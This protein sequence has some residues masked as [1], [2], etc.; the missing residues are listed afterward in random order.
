MCE[1]SE[2][3]TE[4]GC[5]FW[6]YVSGFLTEVYRSELEGQRQALLGIMELN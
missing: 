4:E 6:G 2:G 5:W 1:L 3:I